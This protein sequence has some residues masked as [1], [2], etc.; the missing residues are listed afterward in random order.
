VIYALQ[1][2]QG[3]RVRALLSGGKPYEAKAVEDV[4]RIVRSDGHLDRVL[5][6]T[7]RRIGAA[8]EAIGLLPDGDVTKVL[9]RLGEFLVER[10]EKA[11]RG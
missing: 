9:R 6:E 8:D 7:D 4:I 10:V 1:S 2:S 5:D 11:R 3:D